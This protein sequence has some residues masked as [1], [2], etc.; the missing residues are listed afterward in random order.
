MVLRMVMERKKTKLLMIM[1]LMMAKVQD[2]KRKRMKEDTLETKM[3]E[4]LKRLKV[5]ML[6]HPEV[7]EKLEEEE[8]NV[9]VVKS[10]NSTKRIILLYDREACLKM[11]SIFIGILLVFL[12]IVQIR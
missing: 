10:I 12:I 6:N 4:N 5:P 3:M 7:V 11:L 8:P 9:V 1:N 2:L